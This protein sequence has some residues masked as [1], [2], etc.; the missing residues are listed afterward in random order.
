[1]DD[2]IDMRQQGSRDY[3]GSARIPL[4]ELWQKNKIDSNIPFPIKDEQDRECGQ[5]KVR[6]AVHDAAKFTYD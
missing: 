4:R 3:I 5:V 1:M 2:S 6:M